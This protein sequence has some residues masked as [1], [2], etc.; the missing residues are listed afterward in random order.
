MIGCGQSK[1]GSR[2]GGNAMKKQKVISGTGGPVKKIS[3]GEEIR[4]KWFFYLI[5]IPGIICLLLFS[6]MPMAG[7]Y[8]VFERYT[9]QGGLFGSEFVGLQNFKFFFMN[10]SNA[11]RA[12]KNTLV[13][14]GF[15]I[16][17]GVVVNVGLA[18]LINE[19]NSKVFKKVTQTVMLFPYFI[20]WII[21][22]MVALALF[23]EDTGMINSMLVHFGGEAVEWYSNADYWWAIMIFT[24]VWKG[25][26]Y[27]SIIYYCALSGFDQSL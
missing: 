4:K 6:Y 9:Y 11:L 2:K 26:G 27:G 1:G 17:L 14:N 8:V 23:D 16:V 15:S 10:M 24:T 18:I 7:L 20:S 25:A 22:G 12:T 5:P 3:L 13:I 21:V 19:I